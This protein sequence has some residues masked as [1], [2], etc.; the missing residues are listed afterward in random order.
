MICYLHNYW[1]KPEQGV[2]WIT[3][4]LVQFSLKIKKLNKKKLSHAKAERIFIPAWG[5]LTLPAKLQAVTAAF[6]QIN[7]DL[8][9]LLL[10]SATAVAGHQQ[11]R[12]KCIKKKNKQKISTGDN[13]AHQQHNPGISYC[14][15]LNLGQ[16]RHK[17]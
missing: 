8:F 10:C 14:S 16:A 5:S 1:Q 12:K 2:R 3:A 17:A 4:V 15:S 9:P 7:T 6:L 13:I 11:Q